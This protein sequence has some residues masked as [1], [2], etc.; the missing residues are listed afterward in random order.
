[1][2]TGEVL[3]ENY[4][5]LR[6]YSGSELDSYAQDLINFK[7]ML[8]TRQSKRFLPVIRKS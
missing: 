5:K 8:K 4:Q 1:M 7:C 2:K 3:F 6:D